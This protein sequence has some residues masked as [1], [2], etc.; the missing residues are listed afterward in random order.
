MKKI[1]LI[2]IVLME[3]PGF[4]QSNWTVDSAYIGFQ[5]VNAGIDVNGT[6]NG[7]ES[8][9]SFSR[10]KLKKSWFTASVD[11]GTVD[12]GI[13]IRDKHLRKSDFFDIERYPVITITSM[14]IL[15]PELLEFKASC[16]LDLKGKQESI[17]IPFT[18]QEMDDYAIMQGDFKINR[19]DYQI[20]EESLILSDSVIINIWLRLKEK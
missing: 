12:T 1:L 16:M 18:F 13:R 10:K 6:F 15:E 17:N 11:A 2:I 20:G 19:I 3:Q 4:G 8:L 9:I 14:E 5:I 7:L